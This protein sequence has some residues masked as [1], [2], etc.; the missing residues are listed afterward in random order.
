MF[1]TGLGVLVVVV[2]AVGLAVLVGGALYAAVLS[3]RP[4]ATAK[5]QRNR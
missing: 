4:A 5:V 2:L 1:A 3:P